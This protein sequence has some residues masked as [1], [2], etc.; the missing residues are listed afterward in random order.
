MNYCVFEVT[1]NYLMYKTAFVLNDTLAVFTETR[2]FTRINT[3]VGGKII[4]KQDSSKGYLWITA[5]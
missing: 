1:Q 3:L 2:V 4:A 5:S